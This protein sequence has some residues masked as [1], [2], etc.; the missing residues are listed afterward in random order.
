[1]RQLGVDVSP[2]ATVHTHTLEKK[3]LVKISYVTN[4]T[5]GPLPLH[6]QEIKVVGQTVVGI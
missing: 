4:F 2:P 5:I 6:G 3:K 1:M